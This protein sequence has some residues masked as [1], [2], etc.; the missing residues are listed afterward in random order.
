M[1]QV[2]SNFNLVD[3]QNK[4][5]FYVLTVLSE[6]VVKKET[7]LKSKEDGKYDITVCVASS[8][9]SVVRRNLRMLFF[10]Y[11]SLSRQCIL[12]G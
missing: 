8:I 9:V 3:G 12:A 1:F 2:F 11:F 4:S 7:T 6:K 10:G 5:I